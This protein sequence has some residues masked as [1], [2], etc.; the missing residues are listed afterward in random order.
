MRK[1]MMRVPSR[2]AMMAAVTALVLGAAVVPA[3]AQLD[4]FFDKMKGVFGA[5]EKPQAAAPAP[6]SGQPQGEPPCPSVDIRNGASTLTIYGSGEENATNVR[7]Q[8]SVTQTARECHTLGPTMTV[9]LGVRGRVLLGPVGG[10]GQV[11][12]PIRIALVKEGPEPKTLLS[13]F[14]QTSV[15][16]PEGQTSV[17]FSYV[18]QDL[19]FPV[20]AKDD[21]ENYIFYV[22]FDEQGAKQPKRPAKKPRAKKR[23]SG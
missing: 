21:M 22:G 12:V 19:T 23:T 16:V 15:A 13:K 11:T 17:P 5:D 7:Y 2:P 3:A 1:M 6:Q 9:S 20:A 4:S 18:E 10:Q 14:F 8:V